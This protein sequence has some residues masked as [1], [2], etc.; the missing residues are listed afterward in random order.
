MNIVVHAHCRLLRG[1]YILA[2]E[3]YSMQ[4]ETKLVCS[5]NENYVLIR[6]TCAHD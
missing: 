4:L 5:K 2:L 1:D 6:E 3:D